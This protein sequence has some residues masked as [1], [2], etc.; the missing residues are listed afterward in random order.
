MN[1]LRI[2]AAVT[3]SPV[4][5]GCDLN[6]DLSHGT[7]SAHAGWDRLRICPYEHSV[8]KEEFRIRFITVYDGDAG[9]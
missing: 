8:R 4:A 5:D 2:A 3:R 9:P 1:T 7:D 6:L